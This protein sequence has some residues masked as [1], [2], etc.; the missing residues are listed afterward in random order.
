[1]DDSLWKCFGL[2]ASFHNLKFEE[3]NLRHEFGEGRLGKLEVVLV[4]KKMGLRAKISAIKWRRL[5]K[6]PLP[7]LCSLKG[8]GFALLE[9]VR[10]NQ[11]GGSELLLFSLDG[12]HQVVPEEKARELLDGEIILLTPRKPGDSQEGRKFGVGWFT[13]SLLK[14]R[15]NFGEVLFVSLIT[16]LLGLATPLFFQIVM[17]KVVVHRGLTTLNVLVVGILVAY[18]FECILDVHRTYLLTHTTS[19]IDVK[20]GS[21][22]YRH[23]LGLPQSYFAKKPI[24]VTVACVRELESVRD[25]LTSS[26]TI[27]VLDLL[28]SIIY[29]IVMYIYS[30]HLTSFVFGSLGAYA[31]L[32]AAISPILRRN[33]LDKYTRGAESQAFLV[34][35]VGGIET[36][37]AH[38]VE[39]QMSKKWDDRLAA[40]A[41]ASFRAT[42][43]A[44]IGSKLVM[45]ISK[46]TTVMILWQG[47]L[48]VMDNQL[49][50]GQ[51][52]AFNMFAAR[53][54]SPVIRLANLFQEYQKVSVALTRLK[55]IMDTP[56]E[57]P[58]SLRS[59][60]P[61]LK[62]A[63]EFRGVRFS[64]LDQVRP[65]LDG[66]SLK[67]APGQVVGIVGESG[68]GKS[69]L[70][71]LVQKIYEPSSGAVYLDG[72]N[73][74]LA[75][76]DWLRRQIGVVLQDSRLFAGSVFENIALADPT[77]SPE[78]VINAAKLAGADGFIRKLARGYD[79]S[80]GEA[81]LGLSGGQR[82][83][84]AIA[85]ALLPGPKL[86][87]LD[88]ASSA[89]DY[90]S[91]REIQQNMPR[92]ADGRTVL[93]VSHRLS[94]IRGCDLIA[95]MKEGR[96]IESGTHEE[97][98]DIPDGAYAHLCKLQAP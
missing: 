86:L 58:R 66:I 65:A 61:P 37:K 5:E 96:I 24:G 44:N 46:V 22:L 69:T 67:I 18:V 38:A 21:Q 40:Y 3:E 14:H 59:D 95:V 83:R 87:I 36:V 48:L 43:V 35:S 73:L 77:A 85:R 29:L 7:A 93:I 84:I 32:T 62:G 34:E 54:A 82:Q 81:G 30:P 72:T 33:L 11:E 15:W 75:N 80:V 60:L 51:L 13:P 76:P 17:D 92:I 55:G 57:N 49:T 27:A 8:G 56:T 12:G 26:M 9:G 39:N 19:R 1:M 94:I 23:L 89:L 10:T 31:A 50:I 6:V 79:T 2:V 45:L 20:L 71:K 91:E 28:F 88:E 47:A 78:R 98:R 90:E 64:Y 16:Q 41:Q 42:H 52:I 4:A 25:F 53:V 63:I 68:S 97:L 70:T 74:A